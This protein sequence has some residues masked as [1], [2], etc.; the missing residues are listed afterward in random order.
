MAT[1]ET[2]PTARADPSSSTTRGPQAV[3]PS[4]GVRTPYPNNIIPQRLRSPLAS[5]IYSVLPLPTHNDINPQVADNFFALTPTVDD[6]RTL[7]FRVDHRLGDNDQVFGR[8]SRGSRS[9]WNRRTNE[10]GTLITLDGFFNREARV[11]SNHSAMLPWSHV[12]SPSMFVET[13]V[14]GGNVYYAY[15]GPGAISYETDV[16]SILGTPN[17]FNV[18]GGPYFKGVGFGVALRGINPRNQDTRTLSFEQNYTKMAGTHSFDFGGRWRKEK[19]DVLPDMLPQASSAFTTSPTALYDPATGNAPAAVARTGHSSA[20]FF[21]GLANNY[22][23]NMPPA[24]LRMAGHETS[25]YLQDNWK[26]TKNLTLNLG[27]RWE[28]LPPLLDSTGMLTTFD[29][30]SRS[31]VPEASMDYLVKNG[32]TN[33]AILNS[34]RTLAVRFTTPSEVGMTG[35]MIKTSKTDFAPRVGFAYRLNASGRNFVVRGGYGSYH[36][37]IPARTF[38]EQRLNAPRMGGFSW[39]PNNAARSPDGMSNW[40]LRSKP[41]VIAGQNSANVI[42]PTRSDS[43]ARGVTVRN[44]ANDL[45][46]TVAH[47]WSFTIE[48]EILKNTVAKI[49]YVGTAGRNLEQNHQMNGQPGNYVWFMTRRQPVPTGAYA[50]VAR[51]SFDREVYGDIWVWNKSG[52]SNFS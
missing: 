52:Y 42:D 35:D 48:H 43:I 5:Y 15:N 22:S 49:G 16:A 17:L 21:L 19:V 34:Y 32:Y 27:V 6:Q 44:M 11:E 30:N 26:V 28:Y 8:F 33:E 29:M 47:E 20:S 13:L 23:Q 4:A 24:P 7:T 18:N 2:S 40:H 41:E 46:T 51:R 45:P 50:S 1:T 38:S 9:N 14:T 39:N 3:Q 10:S 36:F 37:T 31:I 12:F 25:L